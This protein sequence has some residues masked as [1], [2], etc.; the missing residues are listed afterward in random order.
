MDTL[1][2][3]SSFQAL[4]QPTRL[5]AWRLLVHHEPVG[6]AAGAIARALKVP[7]NT[8]SSHLTVLAHAGLVTGKRHGRSIIYRANLK[9]MQHLIDFLVQDCC[10]GHP[11]ICLPSRSCGDTQ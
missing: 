6:L 8:L 10:A 4:S 3:T 9:Q 7:H 11:D 1:I 5:Q 2:A